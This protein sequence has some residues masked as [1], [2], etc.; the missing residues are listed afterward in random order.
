MSEPRHVEAMKGGG[1]VR[2]DADFANKVAPLAGGGKPQ[3]WTHAVFSQGALTRR[4][5]DAF[6]CSIGSDSK[7]CAQLL[8]SY[9]GDFLRQDCI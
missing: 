9:F 8:I 6:S 3:R 2:K 4:V 1:P 5:L 7:K